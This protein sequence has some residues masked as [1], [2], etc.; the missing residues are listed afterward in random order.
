MKR[1]YPNLISKEEK[2]LPTALASVYA[3]DTREEKGFVFIL[4]EWDCIFREAQHDTKAQKVYLDF[5]KD[6]FKDRTYV[7]V[8][9]MTGI[10]PVKKYGS[11]SVLNVFDE[12]SMTDPGIMT[13]YVGFTENEVRELCEAYQMEFEQVKRWYD[14]YL[15]A[16]GLHIYNPKSVVDAMKGRKPKSFWTST[17]TYEA[18]QLYIDIDM[19]GLKTALISMLAGEFCKIDTGTFQNDMTSF[20]SRDDIMTLLVH[21][22]Y[23]AYHEEKKSVFIPNEEVRQEFVRAV[24]TGKRAELSKAIQASDRLLQATIRMDSEE[25]AQ[26]LEEIHSTVTA[27]G[28]YN[29]EQ[30]LRSTIRFAYLSSID[31]YMELR[32]LPSG[33]GYADIVFLPLRHSDKPVMVVELKW[34]RPVE[35]AIAQIKD[36]K[37]PEVI[38]KY[39]SE[40]LLVGISY[41]EKT[42]KNSC[43]IEK[44]NIQK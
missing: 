5:P 39:G 28:F 24:R 13:S 2:H 35:G 29:N 20:K 40:I 41:D 32:E 26:I 9:Y 11:H 12:F 43:L 37:Y 23:L 8:A 22:G 31:E 27:P 36:R 10:L 21:L 38:E 34:N 19:D 15:F 16:D 42:K 1:E 7:S 4:D 3:A 44:Y 25:V 33:I 14:G 6:L 18:L 30:A 17:E